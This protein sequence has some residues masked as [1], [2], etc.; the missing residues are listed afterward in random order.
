MVSKLVAPAL[1]FA[2]S[3]GGAAGA[4]GPT[5]LP[6]KNTTLARQGPACAGTQ[7]EP[8]RD[9]DGRLI[10]GT[11]YVGFEVA[12]DGRVSNL[13]GP[14]G[15]RAP[16]PL[17]ASVERWLRAGVFEPAR[18]EGSPISS[19]SA[20]SFSFPGEG[21]DRVP[22]GQ[23]PKTDRATE[24]A[25]QLLG[26][27]MTPPRISCGGFPVVPDEARQ[28]GIKGLVLV[29][30]VVHADGSVGQVELRNPSAPA[31]LFEAVREWLISCPYEPSRNRE[32]K[33]IP[34]KIIQPFTFK[35]SVASE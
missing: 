3:V 29:S 2:F 25:P 22:F 34:V 32:G 6:Q 4:G 15:P 27:G 20:H 21:G 18:D 19:F 5:P 23:L 33:A 13:K 9:A 26:S 8:V 17:L 24:G 1:A 31:I 12:K 7:P 28:R 10:A 35:A 30:F 16:A 14:G 11:V